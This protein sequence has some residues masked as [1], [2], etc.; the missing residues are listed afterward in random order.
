MRERRGI[1]PAGPAAHA[2]ALATARAP[3][4]AAAPARPC[5]SDSSRRWRRAGAMAVPGVPCLAWCLRRVGASCDWLLLEAGTQVSHAGLRPLGAGGWAG[6]SGRSLRRSRCFLQ[7]FPGGRSA[8]SS[9]LGSSRR[10]GPFGRAAL[11]PGL[12]ARAGPVQ[13][14]QRPRA[15]RAGPGAGAFAYF[16]L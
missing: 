13:P 14:R 9:R 5:R 12:L 16:Y 3:S 4:G 8:A 10:S 1:V 15:P 7:R 2:R 11:P 6:L